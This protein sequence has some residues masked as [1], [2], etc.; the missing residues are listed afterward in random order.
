MRVLLSEML[1]LSKVLLPN[2][3]YLVNL[4]AKLVKKVFLPNSKLITTLFHSLPN[5]EENLVL[6]IT[7][8]VLGKDTP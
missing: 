8:L 1:L 3:N 6:V 4:V 7:K 2:S 5:Q